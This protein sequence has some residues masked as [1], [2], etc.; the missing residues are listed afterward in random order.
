MNT[1]Q[2]YLTIARRCQLPDF[3]ADV[4]ALPAADPASGVGN[5]TIAAE[6]ITAILYLHISSGM[7]CGF[8]DRH[9]FIFLCVVDINNRFLVHALFVS[10]QNRQQIFFP[11]ISNQ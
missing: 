6:L 11:V 3:R 10:F 8:H 7:L 5:H 2:H 9:I 4:S 1:G